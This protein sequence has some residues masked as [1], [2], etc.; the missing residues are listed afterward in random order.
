MTAVKQ[1]LPGEHYGT[2]VPFDHDRAALTDENW[3][4]R[5][6]VTKLTAALAERDRLV[7]AEAHEASYHHEEG[8]TVHGDAG[9]IHRVMEIAGFARNHGPVPGPL[10]AAA[11]RAAV[12]EELRGMATVVALEAAMQPIPVGPILEA[13]AKAIRLAA[14]RVEGE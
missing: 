4:L 2:F 7:R 8:W 12:A 11:V 10:C 1:P 3:R 9:G 14:A 13:Q 6:E 5:A